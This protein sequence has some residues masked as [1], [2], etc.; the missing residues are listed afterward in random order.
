MR[1]AVLKDIKDIQLENRPQPE[2][3][4]GEI[5]IKVEYCGICGSDIY[6]YKNLLFPAGTV[7]GHEFSG[8]VAKLGPGVNTWVIGER[9]V[10]RP[11]GICGTC[12]WCKRGQLALCTKHFDNTLGLK[13][14][15]GFAEYVLAK[16]FQ[17]VSLPKN[18]SFEEAAIMEP[19]A[20][21][22]RGVRSS[23]LDL[24]DNVVVIGAGPIGLITMMCA[25]RCGAAKVFVLEK[26]Q[27]RRELA[28]KMGASEVFS[29]ENWNGAKKG[30]LI[31]IVYDCVGSSG[32]LNIAIELVRNGGQVLILGATPEQVSYNQ[33][34]VL[35]RAIDLKHSMGYYVDDFEIAIKCVSAGMFPLGDLISDVLPLERITEGFDKLLDAEASVKILIKP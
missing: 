14:P 1:V 26:S 6:A 24:G 33:T 9:I 34:A 25:F 30:E 29:P 28:L 18:V 20:V 4:A 16:E 31:D 22:I 35:V 7:L 2:P 5:L 10:A 32:T 12:Y 21:C 13:L 11:P 19:L 3:G 23:Q 17:A 15:G 8:T 27:K